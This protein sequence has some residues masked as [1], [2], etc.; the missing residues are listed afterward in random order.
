M[1]KIDFPVILTGNSK[2]K[3][4]GFFNDNP[5][6]KVFLK[7]VLI[8]D[9]LDFI[10]S[11]YVQRLEAWHKEHQVPEQMNVLFANDN[12]TLRNI[13]EDSFQFTYFLISSLN[14]NRSSH[15]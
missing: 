6:N 12:A 9:V 15:Y 5:N 8:P 4:G 3:L 13:F 14:Y 2:T 7:P 11:K 1:K 10:K